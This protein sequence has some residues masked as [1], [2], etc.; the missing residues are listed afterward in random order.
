VYLL[1]SSTGM[2][3]IEIPVSALLQPDVVVTPS[4]LVIPGGG[5]RGRMQQ[6]LSIRSFWTNALELASPAVNNG[7]VGARLDPVAPGRAYEVTLTYPEGFAIPA[8]QRLELRV[9][10][11]HPRYRVLRVPINAEAVAPG[12]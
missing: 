4:R 9:E 12:S 10:T 5:I 3:R 6:V 1:T 8:G 11:N 2:P 7:S